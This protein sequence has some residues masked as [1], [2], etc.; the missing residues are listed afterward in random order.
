MVSSL[1][2]RTTLEIFATIIVPSS[3][4]LY[5]QTS[6]GCLLLAFALGFGLGAA[7]FCI[8]EAFRLVGVTH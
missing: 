4:A 7:L 1:A 5:I 3:V 8:V 2:G 6:C